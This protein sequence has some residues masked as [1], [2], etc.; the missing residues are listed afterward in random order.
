MKCPSNKVFFQFDWFVVICK[1]Y[2]NKYIE[3]FND[4]DND[5]VDDACVSYG[6]Q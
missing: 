5:D 6:F 1:F 4:N 3:R 2:R